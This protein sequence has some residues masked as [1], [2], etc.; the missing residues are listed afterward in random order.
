[1]LLDALRRCTR[2]SDSYLWGRVYTL[3]ALCALEVAHGSAEAR[4]CV[5]DMLELAQRCGM[6]E[7]AVRAQLHNAALGRTAA[8]AV[9]V[10]LANDI[11]NPVLSAV[12]RPGF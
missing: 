8:L 12:N 3:D 2:V 1:L 5:D 9:A 11:G 6:Q 7:L 10:E 4:A